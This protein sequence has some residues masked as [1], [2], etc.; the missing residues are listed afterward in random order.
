[1]NR[2]FKYLFVF[3]IVL[4]YSQPVFAN[5]SVDRSC[6]QGNQSSCG[7]NNHNTYN[8]FDSNGD[9]QKRMRSFSGTYDGLCFNKTY[10]L[11]GQIRIIINQDASGRVTGTITING[12]IG[13][14]N[15]EGNVEDNG[16]IGFTSEDRYTGLR[17]SWRGLITGNKI[18][19]DYTTVVNEFGT[20]EASK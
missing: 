13:T 1:M 19:G 9:P 3:L 6:N 20:W 2:Y 16:M 12:L 8:N 5:H 7:D 4:S 11:V 18:L 10:G 17:I 14:G 15:L